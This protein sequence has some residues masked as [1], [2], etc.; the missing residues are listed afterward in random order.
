MGGGEYIWNSL[1]NS[2]FIS[3]IDSGHLRIK[4]PLILLFPVLFRERK[5]NLQIFKRGFFDFLVQ[6]QELVFT[7]RPVRTV[8]SQ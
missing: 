6:F 4:L 8:G 2:E 5:E 1:R 7:F 3:P